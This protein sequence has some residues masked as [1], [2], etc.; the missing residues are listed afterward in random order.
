MEA[1]HKRHQTIPTH[2]AWLAPG[3]RPRH[4]GGGVGQGALKL[5]QSEGDAFVRKMVVSHANSIFTL[6][7]F[8]IVDIETVV[9]GPAGGAIEDLNESF[10]GMSIQAAKNAGNHSPPLRSVRGDEFVVPPFEKLRRLSTAMKRF[11]MR[12]A[13]SET[14]GVGHA[15]SVA[16]PPGNSERASLFW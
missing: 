14:H 16:H 6:T 2:D 1:L 3:H 5:G 11:G 4:K 12:H 13:S 15:G 8:E 9:P 10:M 7:R